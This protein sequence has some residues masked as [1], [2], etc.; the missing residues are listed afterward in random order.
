MTSSSDGVKCTVQNGTVRVHLGNVGVDIPSHLLCTSKL[1]MD[2]LASVDDPSVGREFTLS[3]PEEWL[4]AWVT[5]YANGEK[6]LSCVDIEGL[7]NCLMV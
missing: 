4:Q 6:R 3:V 5:C 7:V 2:V 1:F